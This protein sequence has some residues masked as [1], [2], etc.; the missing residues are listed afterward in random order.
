MRCGVVWCTVVYMSTKEL[1]KAHRISIEFIGT[2][3]DNEAGRQMLYS[4]SCS[5]G[6][7]RDTHLAHIS[8][9]ADRRIA[10]HLAE[11]GITESFSQPE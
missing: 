2:D 9:N 11:V 5:C 8:T 1:A 3:M 7:M 6:T 4:V 10:Q